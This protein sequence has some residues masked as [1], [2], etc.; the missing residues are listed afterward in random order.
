MNTIFVGLIGDVPMV[1]VLYPRH[2]NRL[3]SDGHSVTT[4]LIYDRCDVPQIPQ[5]GAS[6]NFCPQAKVVTTFSVDG[7]FS[8]SAINTV[9]TS[10]GQQFFGALALDL[11]TATVNIAYYSTE[12]DFFHQ[13]AQI[14]LA[15]ILPGSK[16]AQAPTLLT[17]AM[18]D[19]GASSPIIVTPQPAGFG[20]R[21]G[22]A[23]AG[24]GNAGGSRA[25]IGF[26]WNSVS[27]DYGGVSSPDVNN[28]LI[29]LSY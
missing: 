18:G 16:V 20:E 29:I 1:D 6:G 5:R 9:S 14:F 13:K 15:Q 26:T 21:M 22:V 23:A 7:G 24:S 12:N 27:G 28:H 4:F 2:V 19:V 3:E 25:Y 11:S 17:T 8:W 10:A